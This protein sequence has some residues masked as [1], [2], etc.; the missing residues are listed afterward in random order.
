[1]T[2]ILT[3]LLQA[4]DAPAGRYARLDREYAGNSP[5][6]Y[7]APEAAALLGGRLRQVRA[8]IPKILVDSIVER[9]RITG[10][11]GADVWADWTRCDLD[12]MS[13]VAHREALV[14]GAAYALVWSDSTGR[15]SVSIESAHQMSSLIDPATR[16]VTAALK[17]WETTTTTEATLFLPDRVQRYRANSTGATTAGFKLIDEFDNPLGV[18]PVVRFTNADRL[19]DTEGT[20]EMESVIDLSAALVKLLSDMMIASETSARPRRWATGVE[21]AEDEDGNAVSPFNEGT[22]FLVAEGDAAKFGQLPGADL[23]GYENAVGIIMRQISAVS[24]LPEHMLGIGGDNPTSADAIRAS[25]AALTARAETKMHSLGRSWESVAR[26]LVGV[27]DGADPASVDV[28]VEWADAATRSTAQEA[29]AV[30]KL[31][32]AGILPASFALKRLGYS[33]AEIAEIHAA[34]ARDAVANIDVSKVLG[35]AA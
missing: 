11:S 2:D 35:G 6:S 23:G 4:V 8:N 14:L 3:T 21:L 17:R 20:S 25:E 16:Q 34:R 15:P 32:Q 19:L 13:P 27:R 1:M 18:P 5:L 24:G 12:Q 26:L 29:D 30:V 28:R 33:D 10:F 31:H 7:L 9:L 22:A